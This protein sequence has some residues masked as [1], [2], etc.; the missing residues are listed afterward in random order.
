MEITPRLRK[1]FGKGCGEFKLINPS[2][3]ILIP[4][5]ADFPTQTLA[6][7]VLAKVKKMP[8]KPSVVLIHL[9]ESDTVSDETKEILDEFV[10]KCPIEIIYE[11]HD[12]VEN[13]NDL[14]KAYVEAAIKHDCNKVA[15]PDTINLIGAM[16]I[17]TMC[18]DA[19]FNG[20][21]IAQHVQLSPDQPE[22][23]IIRPFCY[24]Q[25]S[26]IQNFVRKHNLREHP[27]AINVPEEKAIKVAKEAIQ[28]IYT[29][30]ANIHMNLFNSQFTI[31]DKYLGAGDG[32]TREIYNPSD[33]E[34]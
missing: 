19:I 12:K 31:Q 25:D 3:K 18:T 20:P 21:D 13:R 8:Q 4:I 27:E 26:D 32:K 15:I 7:C 30:D 33:D 29:E 28:I 9:Y 23:T 24:M 16:I 11:H 14:L 6:S 1:M 10:K 2:D 34:A 17:A 22:V 5:D